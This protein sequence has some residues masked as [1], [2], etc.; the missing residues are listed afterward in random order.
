MPLLREQWPMSCGG[1]WRGECVCV[2]GRGEGRGGGRGGGG[3][4]GGAKKK[5]TPG[6]IE[7]KNKGPN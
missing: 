1:S 2:E 4:G 5:Q 7:M 6:A 3:G